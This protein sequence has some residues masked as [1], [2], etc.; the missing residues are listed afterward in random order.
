MAGNC[1]VSIWLHDNPGKKTAEERICTQDF[2]TMKPIAN[3]LPTYKACEYLGVSRSSFY[4]H[5]KKHLPSFEMVPRIH[6]YA[7]TDLD[8]YASTKNTPQKIHTG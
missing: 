2:F 8:A 1:L 7:K 3:Y 6:F 4:R 5:V